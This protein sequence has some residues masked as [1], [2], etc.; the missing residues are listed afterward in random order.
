MRFPKA[1]PKST[2]VSNYNQQTDNPTEEKP[3]MKAVSLNMAGVSFLKE[4]TINLNPMW[5]GRISEKGMRIAILKNYLL[6][7]S[8]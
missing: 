8:M 4:W 3:C 5:E 2:Y 6:K 1:S 7:I